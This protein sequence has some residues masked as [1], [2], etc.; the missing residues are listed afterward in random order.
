M[1]DQATA[2]DDAIAGTRFND[3]L[4]GAA[5]NDMLNGGLGADVFV[6]AAGDGQDTIADYD[7]VADAIEF[8]GLVFSDL[9]IT[10]AGNHVEIAYG[11][12]DLLTILATN[13]SDFVQSE[14]HF[15]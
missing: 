3:I 9:T 13:A 10:Q 12:A 1:A 15:V 7:A 2:G 5:G 14:F 6:F 11:T 8:Q 4:S